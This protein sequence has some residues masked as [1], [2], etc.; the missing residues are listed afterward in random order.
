MCVWGGVF[1]G[2]LLTLCVDTLGPEGKALG[3]FVFVRVFLLT[4]FCLK[5]GLFSLFCKGISAQLPLADC[6]CS[7]PFDTT[8]DGN[9][10][11]AKPETIKG[12]KVKSNV[13]MCVST[14]KYCLIKMK[15]HVYYLPLS[16][17]SGFLR[18]S[19]LFKCQL[20]ELGLHSD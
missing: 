3:L 8:E 1:W 10:Q 16:F 2:R 5:E 12:I 17:K 6:K 15:F 19:S 14:L 7:P 9:C 13:S 18:C 20:G 11:T 4:L